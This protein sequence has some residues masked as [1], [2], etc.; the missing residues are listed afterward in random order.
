MSRVC[1]RA[2]TVH[3]MSGLM[4]KGAARTDTGPVRPENEDTVYASPRIVAVADGVGGAAAGE[5]ASAVVI[6]QLVLMD[7]CR[8]SAPLDSALER[9]VRSANATVEFVASCRPRMAGMSTTLTAVA[10]RD[11]QYAVAHIGDSRAYLLRDGVLTQ[12]TRD[13]SYVQELLESGAIDPASARRHPNRSL[14]LR[15][16]DGDPQRAPTVAVRRA[17]LGDRLLL[18][19]DGLSDFVGDEVLQSTLSRHSL[20]RSAQDLV[21]LALRAGGRDNISVIVADVVERNEPGS[22]WMTVADL[23]RA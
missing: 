7:K 11:D 16:L 15:A 17:R 22:G 20:E 6:D 3:R 12:L 21:D 1:R 8:L 9:A 19:S 4:L 2:G 10:L 14:V 5:V 18:C 13:D 23:E